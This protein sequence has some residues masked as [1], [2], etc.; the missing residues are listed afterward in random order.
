VGERQL[1]GDVINGYL[2][3]VGKSWG[4]DGLVS[5]KEAAG[6]R[7]KNIVAKE[8]YDNTIM[9][10]ILKWISK[11]H[12][13][14]KVQQAGNYTLKNLGILA[15]LV[16]FMDMKSMLAK[17]EERYNQAYSFGSVEV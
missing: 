16:R 12:G 11:T 7:D 6:I 15:Y 3:F 10:N 1:R 17:A 5:C 14:D 8:F 13:M 9:V 2:K 4:S